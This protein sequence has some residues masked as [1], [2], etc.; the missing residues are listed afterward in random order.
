ML[1]IDY[2]MS[3]EGQRLYGQLGYGSARLDINSQ[4]GAKPIQKLYLG[5]RPGY[6]QEFAHWSKL[7]RDVFL[8]R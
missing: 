1:L 7:Y 8:R 5:N 3:R 2:L 4:A 6:V